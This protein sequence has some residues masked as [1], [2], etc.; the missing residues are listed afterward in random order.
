MNEMVVMKLAKDALWL[1][2]L[3]SAPALL[4]GLVIGLVVSVFQAV[5]SIQEMTLA[6]IPKI[7][8]VFAALLVCGPWSLR[9]LISYTQQI[10]A[11]IPHYL[12]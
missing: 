4:V 6:L 12:R 10:I 11:N 9:L 2:L 7:L 3:L 8:A 5:T 1:I